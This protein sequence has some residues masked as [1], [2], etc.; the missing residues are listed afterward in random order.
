M[1]INIKDFKTDYFEFAVWHWNDILP[2]IYLAGQIVYY[3][4]YDLIDF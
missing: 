3:H 2:N 4:L 1:T